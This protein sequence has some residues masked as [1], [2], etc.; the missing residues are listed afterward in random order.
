M[1][2]R[3]YV[4]LLLT[5]MAVTLLGACSSSS[6][7]SLSTDSRMITSG[8]SFGQSF[9]AQ[10][11]GL[12]GISVLLS[13]A[14]PSNTGSL[15]FHLR[16]DSDSVEDIE[17]AHLPLSEITHNGYYLFDFPAQTDSQ[18]KDYFLQ[19]EVEGQGQVQVF[20]NGADTYL[21]GAL[22]ENHIPQEAQLAFQL[23]YDR[24]LFLVG[25]AQQAVRWAG[26]LLVGIF[27]FILPGWAVFSW[28]WRGWDELILVTK[29]GLSAGLSLAIYPLLLLW[30][31]L[32]GLHLGAF[33][34]WFPPLA[35]L[36]ALGWKY[37]GLILK[38]RLRPRFDLRASLSR[39][40]TDT[41]LA[42]VAAVVIIG[43][44]IVSRLWV[45]SSLD[46]PLYGDS[47]QHTL[48]TQLIIDHGGLFSSWQPYADLTSLT[49]HFGF[50][51]LAAVFHW[52]TGAFSARAVLWTG[53]LVNILSIISLYPLAYKITRSRW[54]GVIAMLLGG[55]LSSMPMSYTNWGR[56]TQL[57][58]Q[59]IMAVAVWITWSMLERPIPAAQNVSLLR[60]LTNWRFLSLRLGGLVIAWLAFG[61]LALTHYRILLV[62]V[63]FIPVFIVMSLRRSSLISLLGRVFWIGLGG[64]IL[65]IPWFIHIYGGKLLNIVA[66]SVTTLPSAGGSGAEIINN[67]KN[68]QSYFPNVTWILFILCIAIGIW[69][70]KK[71][72]AIFVLWWLLVTL[73]A[74]PQWMRLPGDYVLT[75]FT[76]FIAFYIPVAVVI[77]SIAGWF[78]GKI[79]QLY[80]G[81]SANGK[82]PVYVLPG[83][84]LPVII[85]LGI[86]GF[87]KRIQ[88]FQVA[89]YALVTRPDIRAMAWI[90]ENTP[91]EAI[92]LVNSFFAYSDTLVAGSD[93]GWWL[94][95]LAGRETSLPPLTYGIEEGAG[96]TG[97]QQTNQLAQEIKDKGIRSDQVITLLKERGIDYIYVGQ[98]QGRVNYNGP[99]ILD[100][101]IIENDPNFE[102]IYHQ[103]RVWIFKI[104]S[105][106]AHSHY[107]VWI[108]PR[109]T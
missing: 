108:L 16:T 7:Q 8:S 63:L 103:D 32:V 77:G 24:W 67:L 13:P 14:N 42:D 61:G 102:T 80:E 12:S 3:P 39:V 15:V 81:I 72:L 47:Y 46:V 59:T 40:S 6:S 26:V 53:Q 1:K 66:V 55:L 19:V 105:Q 10:N 17:A 56:Y 48:I 31:S 71:D 49:Y 88:D 25:V 11:D 60:R 83:I 99:L 98:R 62:S 51:S 68:L 37:R 91:A 69:Q 107:E 76:V 2:S 27:A 38:N 100:P 30:T 21:D 44:V 35:G 75:Y 65:F 89:P 9:T 29:I 36:L 97:L 52:I 104:I 84:L 41:L 23:R 74:N 70:R 54:A 79:S 18:R 50:H 20:T 43:L 57:A 33:Y 73:A 34:A 92:F 90:R 45:V 78:I 64:A 96:T 28:L 4:W 93:G 58:G 101:Q 87:P 95:I 109:T 22:Y 86:W 106:T 94:P 82:L 5:M 85:A